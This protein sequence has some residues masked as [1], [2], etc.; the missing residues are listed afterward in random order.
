MMNGTSATGHPWWHHA[1]VIIILMSGVI[2]A[3]GI[4]RAEYLLSGFGLMLA[5]TAFLTMELAGDRR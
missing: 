2:I 4:V 5:V 3:T 1:A